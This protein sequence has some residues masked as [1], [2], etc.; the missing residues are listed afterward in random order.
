MLALV[1]AVAIAAN[2][3]PA[4]TVL[5]PADELAALRADVAR[6][7]SLDDTS[8]RWSLLAIAVSI[9]FGVAMGAGATCIVLTST[10]PRIHG[11]C[12]H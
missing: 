11:V 4:K 7:Q 3:A 2:D 1:L 8:V 5:V 6:L 9:V 12:F 10:M